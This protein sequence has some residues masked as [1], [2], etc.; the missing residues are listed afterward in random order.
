MKGTDAIVQTTSASQLMHLFNCAF[1]KASS[2]SAI[3]SLKPKHSRGIDEVSNI[4][5][6]KGSFVLTPYLTNL[7]NLSFSEGT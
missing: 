6:I 5:L 1:T 4:L 2:A 7:I 3:K